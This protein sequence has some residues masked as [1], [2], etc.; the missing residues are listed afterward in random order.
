MIRARIT[1]LDLNEIAENSVVAPWGIGNA[2][3]ASHQDSWAP[4]TRFL[5]NIVKTYRPVAV[6]ECGVYLGTSTIHM[7]MGHNRTQIVGVDIKYHPAAYN[8]VRA[9]PNIWLIEGNT[10]DSFD[11]VKNAIGDNKI[12]LMFID[13][14]HDGVTPKAEFELYR[15]LFGDVC[16][17]ACDDVKISPEME[18]FWDWLPGYKIRLDFLHPIKFT[19]IPD[20]PDPG[21]G[22]SIVRRI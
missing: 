7:A 3:L 22:V 21:F 8:N 1:T 16:I 5:H 17:V 9:Y 4:Y 14:A 11:A 15:P 10:L 19:H 12:E 2:Q 6:L 18:D 20:Y 13:S